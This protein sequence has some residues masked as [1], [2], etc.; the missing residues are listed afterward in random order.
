MKRAFI[1]VLDSFGIGS[2]S[3]AH[4]FNDVGANTF[5][6]IVKY[7]YLGKANHGR[8]GPLCVPNLVSLGLLRAAE[9]SIGKNLFGIDKNITIKGS[10]AY[11]SEISSGKDTSSGHW[12]IAGVPVLYDW[13]YFSNVRNSFPQYILDKIVNTCDLPGF[14]GNCHSSGTVILNDFGEEHINTKKPIFYTSIDSVFQVACHETIFGL[15]KL[16]ALCRIIRK[17]LDEEKIN[18]GR[19]IARPF[20]GNK[21][22]FFKRTGN[23]RDFSVKP[24]DMTVMKKLINEKLGQVVSIGKISDIYAGEGITKQVHATGLLELFNSTIY[25]IEKSQHNTIVFVNFVDFDALWGHR[26]DVSGYAK[27]LEWFD[28]RIPKLLHLIKKDDILIITAD[29]GCDPTWIGTDHTRENVPILIYWPTIEPKFL[30]HRKTFSDIAQTL[31]KYF[32][33]SSMKFGKEMFC[34]L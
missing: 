1:I 29:H 31:A 5:G 22:F 11:A 8:S 23:R 34:K 14:L 32:G 7:C 4:K 17:I 15:K 10:Y 28:S 19:V 30:G 26:R 13:D 3:D 33:L 27:G 12:E 18:I 6:N 20:V 16:Y 9:K 21:R 24:H 25:E 2:T